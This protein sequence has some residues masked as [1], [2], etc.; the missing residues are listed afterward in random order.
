MFRPRLPSIF[1]TS[2]KMLRLPR[3]LHRVATSARFVKDMRRD[4]SKVVRLPCEMTQSAAPCRR[5]ATHLLKAMQKYCACHTKRLLTRHE[6]CWN[7]TKSHVCH[8]TRGYAT[9]ETSQSDHCCKTRHR[10]GHSDLTRTVA[11]GCGQLRT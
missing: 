6:T 9:S 11:N 5:T 10:H 7:V 3:D 8:A 1:S 4:T 2:H